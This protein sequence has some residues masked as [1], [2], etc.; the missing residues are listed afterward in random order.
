MKRIMLSLLATFILYC[1]YADLTMGTLHS[2]TTEYKA[3]T[4]DTNI[5]ATEITVKQGDT[6]LSLIE[7][8][9]DGKIP[10]S[11]ETLIHDFET[12]NSNATPTTMKIGESYYIPLYQDIKSP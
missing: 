2:A 1:V 6:L 3:D 7:T 4:T 5:H 8:L 12:Y 10:V 11:I 9:H